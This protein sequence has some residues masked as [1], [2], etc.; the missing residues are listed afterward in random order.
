MLCR[1]NQKLEQ[2]TPQVCGPHATELKVI[3]E[4]RVQIDQ[5]QEDSEKDEEDD[6]LASLA[7]HSIHWSADDRVADPDA[8]RDNPDDYKV[9]DPLLEKGKAAFNKKQQ[10]AK[11]RASEWAGRPNM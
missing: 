6:R 1:G 4:S 11:K 9:I 3:S 10:H 8:R 2:E 7:S 5:Y